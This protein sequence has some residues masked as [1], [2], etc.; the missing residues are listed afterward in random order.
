MI[1][2][3]KKISMENK[4]NLIVAFSE[5][6][7]IGKDND[8]LWYLPEDLK[9]FKTLTINKPIIMGR[10]TFESLPH[11]L[12]NRKHIVI[13]RDVNYK[14]DDEDI[15]ITNSLNE[16]INTDII[17]ESEESFI[18]GGGEIYKQS[19]DLVDNMYIT[20]VKGEYEADTFFPEYNLSEWEVVES[21]YFNEYSFFKL[22]KCNYYL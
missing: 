9:R 1:I 2:K 5:N 12:P 19:I 21:Q 13:T 17:K 10:K 7:A 8:L 3:E 16:V 22:K 4:L 14:I 15:I 6:R 11:K 18:I 20:V